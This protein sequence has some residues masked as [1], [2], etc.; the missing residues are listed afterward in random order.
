MSRI[1]GGSTDVS[2]AFKVSSALTDPSTVTL[3]IKSPN[4]TETALVYGTDDEVERVSAGVYTS[5]VSLTAAGR[6][7]FRY[8]GT[9][10]CEAA[11]ETLITVRASAVAGGG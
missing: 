6:W 8:E 1:V 5:H 3:W 9:G 2:V 11:D 7:V 4:G 10:A